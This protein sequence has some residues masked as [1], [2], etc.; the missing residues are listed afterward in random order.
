MRR[1]PDMIIQPHGVPARVLVYGLGGADDLTLKT[2]CVECGVIL[3]SDT[4][5]AA[6]ADA[7]LASA[8][9]GALAAK[10]GSAASTRVPQH[11]MAAHSMN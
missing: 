10:M 1:K 2:Q 5:T 6:E 9:P 4:V 7:D 8:N 3:A 11:Y